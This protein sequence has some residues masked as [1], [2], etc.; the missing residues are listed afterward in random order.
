MNFVLFIGRLGQDSELQY[1]SKGTPRLKFSIAVDNSYKDQ[2][3]V[4]WVKCEAWYLLAEEFCEMRKGSLV[5][6]SGRLKEDIWEDKE[7]VKHTKWIVTCKEI[8]VLSVPTCTAP[9]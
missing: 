5:S 7:G 4:L 2:K 9:S 8:R 6:V 3:M 1:T